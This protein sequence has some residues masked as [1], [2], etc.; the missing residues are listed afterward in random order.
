VTSVENTI[1]CF[2]H[3]QAA[4]RRNQESESEIMHEVSLKHWFPIYKTT[5]QSHPWR[6]QHEVMSSWKPHIFTFGKKS[7]DFLL[8]MLKP[9]FY[10]LH[11]F[12][13]HNKHTFGLTEKGFRDF[14]PDHAIH[15]NWNFI[16]F[17]NNLMC[18]NLCKVVI[19]R[20]DDDFM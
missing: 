18:F 13:F 15:F 5:T 17:F 3:W 2:K 1:K 12:P 20:D 11:S 8:N 9:S 4:Q 10:H 19:I 16:F 7:T 6:P 14:L